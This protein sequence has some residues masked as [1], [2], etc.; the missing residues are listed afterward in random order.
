MAVIRKQC[1]YYTIMSYETTRLMSRIANK[2][3]GMKEANLIRLIPVV[4]D[5]PVGRNLQDHMHVDGLLTIPGSIEA[6]AFVSTRF[7]NESLQF[8]DVQIAL[9]LLSS[10]GLPYKLYLSQMGVS[11][12]VYDEYYGPHFPSFGYA[13]VPVMNRPKSRGYIKLRTTNPL[14]KPIIDPQYL[15]HPRDVEVAVEGVK[16]ARRLMLSEAMREI[17]AEPWNDPLPECESAGAIWSDGY[18]ACFVRH[19][20]HTTWHACCTCPMG[21]DTRAVVDHTLRNTLAGSS[22]PA[23]VFVDASV[24]PTIVTGNPNVPTMMIAE[25]AAAMILNDHP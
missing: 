25:K 19:M 6:L 22:G 3:H 17:K 7:E 4:A 8:P 20:A 16:I 14:D 24:M 12:K 15:T 13:L 18:L 1:N 10:S 11:D 2:Q 9:Q 21:N 23:S 5:L